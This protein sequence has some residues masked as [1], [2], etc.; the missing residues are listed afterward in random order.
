MTHISIPKSSTIDHKLE[1]PSYDH[2][3]LRVRSVFTA[4]GFASAVAVVG[5]ELQLIYFEAAATLGFAGLRRKR[6]LFEIG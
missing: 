5:A 4:T 3:A 6:C 2:A 1:S